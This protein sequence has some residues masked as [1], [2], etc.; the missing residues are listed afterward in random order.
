MITLVI[1]IQVKILKL[2][3][4]QK[5]LLSSYT[6]VRSVLVF[7]YF[8]V[9]VFHLQCVFQSTMTY[10]YLI[11]LFVMILQVLLA[12][13]FSSLLNVP[14]TFRSDFCPWTL[15]KIS[16]LYSLFY[17]MQMTPQ[18]RGLVTSCLIPLLVDD[19]CVVVNCCIHTPQFLYQ[20]LCSQPLRWAA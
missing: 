15:S 3:D 16:Y 20:I 17:C 12:H 7:K 8:I 2:P 5:I 9:L 10:S 11:Y 13:I 19:S 14:P 6:Q 4:I 1:L 18:F